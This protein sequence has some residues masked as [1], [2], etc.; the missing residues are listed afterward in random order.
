MAV[1]VQQEAIFTTVRLGSTEC[2]LCFH[3]SC[4]AGPLKAE[5]HS[6]DTKTETSFGVYL[7]HRGK[8]GKHCP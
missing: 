3:L 2:S 7:C 1:L 4:F 6:G 8:H 5:G